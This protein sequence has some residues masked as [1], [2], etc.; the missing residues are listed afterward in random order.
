MNFIGR[1]IVA[2]VVFGL[3]MTRFQLRDKKISG[4][5]AAIKGFAL[6]TAVYPL[7]IVWAIWNLFKW[8]YKKIRRIVRKGD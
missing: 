2:A 8:S 6:W 1:Y 5:K 4:W 7:C 3:L